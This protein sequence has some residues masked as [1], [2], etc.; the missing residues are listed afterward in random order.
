MFWL[1]ISYAS[2]LYQAV[3]GIFMESEILWLIQAVKVLIGLITRS[4]GVYRV[5]TVFKLLSGIL[6]QILST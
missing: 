2:C 3:M 5:S 6:F 4:Y 1:I